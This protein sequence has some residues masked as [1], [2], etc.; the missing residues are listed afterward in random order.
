VLPASDSP[1]SFLSRA[2]MRVVWF[3]LVPFYLFALGA[4]EL[5]GST[6]K[7]S[8]TFQKNRTSTCVGWEGW[9]ERVVDVKI[10]EQALRI[11]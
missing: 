7:P 9:E 3:D 8:T 11:S 10:F 2:L 4:A 6:R 5:A 1:R